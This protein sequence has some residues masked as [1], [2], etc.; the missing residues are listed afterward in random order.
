[1]KK[2]SDTLRRETTCSEPITDGLNQTLSS[3]SIQR[4]LK[5]AALALAGIGTRK[6]YV[7]KQLVR[8]LFPPILGVATTGTD[9]TP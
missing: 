3:A 5:T 9:F 2:L 1:M 4:L 7:K 8:S 6:L